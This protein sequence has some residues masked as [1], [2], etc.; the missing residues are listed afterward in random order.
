MKLTPE[1]I[2]KRLGRLMLIIEYVQTDITSS[3]DEKRQARDDGSYIGFLIAM[4]QNNSLKQ[5]DLQ[6][7]NQIWENYTA[8]LTGSNIPESLKVFYH[9]P[10]DKS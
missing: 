3:I 10:S 5:I 4:N 6:A 1:E 2:G 7:A 8:N 9:E